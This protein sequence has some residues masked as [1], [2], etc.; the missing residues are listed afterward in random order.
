MAAKVA[1]LLIKTYKQIE[2]KE[3]N[4]W[5]YEEC[6]SNKKNARN[7]GNSVEMGQRQAQAYSAQYQGSK[8]DSC[9][10]KTSQ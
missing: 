5:Y 6:K 9:T 1:K 2:E 7:K 8:R 4:K 3:T 10:G